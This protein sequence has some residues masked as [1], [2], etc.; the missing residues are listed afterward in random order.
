MAVFSGSIE[1]DM[2]AKSPGP[3][4]SA[5]THAHNCL[6]ALEYGIE[7]YYPDFMAQERRVEYLR[8]PVAYDRRYRS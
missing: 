3:K 1:S 2:S 8:D 4:I 6:A 5:N 7:E